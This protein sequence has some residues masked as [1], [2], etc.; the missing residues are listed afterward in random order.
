MSSRPRSSRLPAPTGCGGCS[1]A[2]APRCTARQAA[3]LLADLR[4]NHRRSATR[5]LVSL[6]AVE[7]RKEELA[8]GAAAEIDGDA[9]DRAGVR[10][11][12]RQV[13]RRLARAHVEEI[14]A[15]AGL[16]IRGNVELI[17]DPGAGVPFSSVEGM[18]RD[19]ID[20]RSQHFAIVR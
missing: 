8:R 4:P 13:A 17:V 11:I 18:R 3:S 16:G 12:F 7:A 15:D 9:A 14:L 6:E 19:V 5:R 10:E 20:Q 2:A 1:S